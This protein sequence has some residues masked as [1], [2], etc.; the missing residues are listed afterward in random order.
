MRTATARYHKNQQQ[1]G[2]E[3][4]PPLPLTFYFVNIALSEKPSGKGKDN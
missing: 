2:E 1:G 4:V 3:P